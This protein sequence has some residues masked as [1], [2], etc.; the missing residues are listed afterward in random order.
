[1]KV[2]KYVLFLDFDE[3]NE[4]FEGIVKILLETRKNKVKLDKED[5]EIKSVKVNG[6]KAEF[7]DRKNCLVVKCGEKIREIEIEYKGKVNKGLCGLYKAQNMY[8]T[9]L[10]AIDARRVF[11]CFDDPKYKAKFKISVKVRKP[12]EVI[13]NEDVEEIRDLGEYRVFD[14]KETCIM[15]TYL[16]YIG[17]GEFEKLVEKNSITFRAIVPKGKNIEKAKTSLRYT[18][19][20]FNF[21]QDYFKVRY[22][23]SKLDII[24]VPEFAS[25][26]MENF[27]AIT[28]REFY[29][30]TD[31]SSSVKIKRR[32]MEII[33]H[34]LVHQ[35][36]GNLVTLKSWD[37]LW[38]NE[39]F[40]TYLA[41]LMVD[42]IYPKEKIFRDFFIDDF[43]GSIS[44]DS[45]LST[46]PIKYKVKRKEEVEQIFDSISYG[47]GAS[48][49]RMLA[50]YFGEEKFRGILTKYLEENKFS[51]VDEKDFIKF[52]GNEGG[53]VKS[54]IFNKGHPVV[55]LKFKKGGFVL[56]QKRF[57]F[58]NKNFKQLWKIPIFVKT[59][60]G[61]KKLIL[62]KKSIKVDLNKDEF[63][64][65][66]QNSSG[67]YH[68]FYDKALLKEVF[69]KKDRLNEFEKTILVNDYFSFLLADMISLDEFL[70]I[71]R[72][73]MKDKDFL[74]VKEI[75]DDLSF[76]IKILDNNK[77][78]KKVALDFLKYHFKRLDFE[79]EE[80][81]ILLSSICYL[82]VRIDEDFCKKF[83]RKFK[84]YFEVKPDLRLAY[85]ISLVKNKGKE[86]FE[87]ILKLID[88]VGDEDRIKLFTSL[89]FSKEES[90]VALA[91]SFLEKSKK[92]DLPIIILN[93]LAEKKNI[94]VAWIWLKENLPKIMEIFK[95]TP[96][97]KRIIE[98]I[99]PAVG[100]YKEDE[101]REYFNKNRFEFASIGIK[102]GF[103][104]LEVLKRLKKKYG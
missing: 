54:W 32:I 62:D 52:L 72:E 25:G 21:M 12:L 27:G 30:L 102:N 63:L 39:S 19:E 48:V 47:K 44:A 87:E 65:L 86:G 43:L 100:L 94:E 45:L 64:F 93:S 41:F 70:E 42:K 38:L 83:F 2:E 75:T 57:S 7:E 50:S 90:L 104:M 11:P 35:W 28:F 23:L 34:E 37:D 95:G 49:L 103:E 1:M 14:F 3:V 92:Q 24:V 40:A 78:I 8:S 101:V 82:Y 55:F 13:S 4:S 96:Q 81:L 69:R 51:N 9:Q 10:E 76:L 66:N 77:K 15:P 74:V 73:F 99:I 80:D 36:F 85:A 67:Y 31:E 61:E 89:F 53:L 58:L 46:H 59:N 5:L 22:P 91:Y 26:A 17:I 97:P 71:V 20:L 84:N 60:F 16:V 98:S 33:S 18:K 88:K 79:K 56:E 29:V 68:V 6:K